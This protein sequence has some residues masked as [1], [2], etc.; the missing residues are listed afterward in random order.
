MN[1]REARSRPRLP[2]GVPAAVAVSAGPV[3]LIV[4]AAESDAADV[5]FA[6]A[7][8]ARD[9][10]A[11]LLIAFARPR[12]GFTT[13]PVLVRFVTARRKQEMLRLERLAHQVLDPPGITFE[14]VLMTYRGGG[15]ESGRARSISSALERLAR[16]RGAI[17]WPTPGAVLAASSRENHQ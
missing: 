5:L 13:D 2:G 6:A 17:R 9:A 1:N 4:I 16:V 11:R 12:L 7:M 8:Q 14:T 15:S 3:Y 10:G